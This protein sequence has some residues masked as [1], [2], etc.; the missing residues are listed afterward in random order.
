[1]WN[2]Y[3]NSTKA[4]ASFSTSQDMAPSWLTPK[5]HEMLLP[6]N[7]GSVLKESIAKNYLFSRKKGTRTAM[8]QEERTM[9]CKSVWQAVRNIG[10]ETKIFFLGKWRRNNNKNKFFGT[11]FTRGVAYKFLYPKFKRLVKYILIIT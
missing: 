10:I 7:T 11:H 5:V 3:L 4:V 2:A 9:L 8:W 1:M 6:A